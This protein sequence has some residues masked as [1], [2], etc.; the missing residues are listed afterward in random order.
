MRAV[1]DSSALLAYL[2]EDDPHAELATKALET[3]YREGKLLIDSVVYAEL[4][5][6]EGF[7]DETEIDQFLD[8]TG[9]DV[10]SPSNAAMAAAGAAF[11]EYLSRRGDALQC[12][13]CGEQT[14]VSCPE[15]G[16]RLE[17]RQHLSP[18]FLIGA[19]AAVDAD[20]LITFDAGFYRSYFDV[21]IRPSTEGSESG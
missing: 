9:I 18:D 15:C 7:A 2:Y 5:G 17:P 19:H 4:A 14:T 21:D 11:T 12:P 3:T 20:V 6:E 13:A 10:E 1:V 16:R 8:E